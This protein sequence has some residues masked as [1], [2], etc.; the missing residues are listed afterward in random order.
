M[1]KLNVF[2][3]SVARTPNTKITGWR[4]KHGHKDNTST[5][6]KEKAQISRGKASPVQR[7]FGMARQRAYKQFQRKYFVALNHTLIS[8]MFSSC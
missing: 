5:Q 6:A 2:I 8:R 7:M 1:R 4:R 3:G